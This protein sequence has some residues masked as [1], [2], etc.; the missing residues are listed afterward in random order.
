[1]PQ[2]LVP[3]LRTPHHTF[4]FSRFLRHISKEIYMLP[5]QSKAFPHKTLRRTSSLTHSPPI[6]SSLLQSL[7]LSGNILM[8]PIRCFSIPPE[9]CVSG[10]L[11]CPACIMVSAQF[12]QIPYLLVLLYIFLLRKYC[13][14]YFFLSHLIYLTFI[15][16]YHHSHFY[17]P[18]FPIRIFI[19][20][21]L[22]AFF[23]D[24][25]YI[26]DISA[27]ILDFAFLRMHSARHKN[28]HMKISYKKYMKHAI[29]IAAIAKKTLSILTISLSSFCPL[30]IGS[31]NLYIS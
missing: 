18:P 22:D 20:T 10:T 12:S 30:S 9:L 16:P 23:R 15:I 8:L 25:I 21:S 14:E 4:C 13:L 5:H 31:L 7:L 28:H 19:N 2:S 3:S 1:M 11:H 6:S 29:P 27:Q 17:R 26:C 24:I